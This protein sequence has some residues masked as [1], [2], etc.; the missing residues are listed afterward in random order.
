MLN[1][2]TAQRLACLHERQHAHPSLFRPRRRTAGLLLIGALAVN[3]FQTAPARSD[4]TDTEIVYI[5]A[6]AS[7]N[8]TPLDFDNR[9]FRNCKGDGMPCKEAPIPV[10]KTAWSAVQ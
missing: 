7:R 6:N 2:P 5:L 8:L 10:H 3:L 4:G 9:N 1:G